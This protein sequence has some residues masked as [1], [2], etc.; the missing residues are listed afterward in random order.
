MWS[1]INTNRL[2]L[3]YV[4]VCQLLL[5]LYN[6]YTDFYN[7][8]IEYFI[9]VPFSSTS[10][11]PTPTGQK[12]VESALFP[13]YFNPRQIYVMTLNEWKSDWICKKSSAYGHSVSFFNM[14][15]M[16]W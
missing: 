1:R 15:P 2:G 4:F 9:M 16:T 13:R 12:L 10:W 14:N 8:I 11:C 6:V 7:N 3:C 5:A